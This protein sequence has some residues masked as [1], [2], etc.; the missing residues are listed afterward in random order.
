MGSTSVLVVEDNPIFRETAMHVLE[1]LRLRVFG[2][3][4]GESALAFIAGHREIR[5]IFIPYSYAGHEWRRSRG[6]GAQ[7]IPKHKIVSGYVRAEAAPNGFPFLLK[8]WRLNDV[9][10]AITLA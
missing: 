5:L 1:N 4:N 10:K 2:A 3:Y 9:E 8:P 7:A 6:S